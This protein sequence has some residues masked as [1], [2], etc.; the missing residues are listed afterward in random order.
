MTLDLGSDAGK[1]RA[2]AELF[3]AKVSIVEEVSL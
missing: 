1:L 3:S 2:S